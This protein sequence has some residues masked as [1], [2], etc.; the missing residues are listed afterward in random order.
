MDRKDFLKTVGVAGVTIVAA[1][2]IAEEKPTFYGP[3]CCPLD[4]Q[5]PTVSFGCEMHDGEVYRAMEVRMSHKW[6]PYL[7]P[8]S[9]DILSM[10]NRFVGVPDHRD[11]NT[12]ESIMAGLNCCRSYYDEVFIHRV[13]CNEYPNLEIIKFLPSFYES[14]K[15]P[16][17]VRTLSGTFNGLSDDCTPEEWWANANKLV[18]EMN[19]IIKRRKENRNEKR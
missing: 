10:R 9:K 15:A 14:K 7:E 11:W 8:K 18:E 6:F 13:Y 12:E 17:D 16:E 4:W 5:I 1:P 19:Q 2:L 3:V